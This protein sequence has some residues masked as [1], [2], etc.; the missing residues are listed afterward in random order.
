MCAGENR[1]V[2]IKSPVLSL[3]AMAMLSGCGCMCA[4]ARLEGSGMTPLKKGCLN[5]DLHN[6]LCLLE[7]RDMRRRESTARLN[8]TE[9]G[10]FVSSSKS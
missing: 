4:Q 7:W 2:A 1:Q 10:T 5:G 8:C 3:V 6:D 9:A